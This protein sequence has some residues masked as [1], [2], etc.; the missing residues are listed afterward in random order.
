MWVCCE[1]VNMAVCEYIVNIWIW[2][3]INEYLDMAVCEHVV[4]IWI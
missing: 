3:W 1:Y 2:I 4:N